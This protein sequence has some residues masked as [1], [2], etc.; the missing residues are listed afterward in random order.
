[1]DKYKVQIAFEYDEDDMIDIISSAVYDINYWCIIDNTTDDWKCV[2]AALPS[3]STFEDVMWT[4]LKTERGIR[5]EDAEDE[6]G[7]WELTLEKLQNGIRLTIQNG[8]WNGNMDDIDGF[9]GDC[10]FQYA[11]FGELVYG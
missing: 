11:L 8:H 4:L 10:V 7:P 2:S 5:L 1:M 6:D 3:D 9:V